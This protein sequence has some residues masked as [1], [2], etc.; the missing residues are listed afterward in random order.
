MHC[1]TGNLDGL[2]INLHHPSLQT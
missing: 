1:T 2:G